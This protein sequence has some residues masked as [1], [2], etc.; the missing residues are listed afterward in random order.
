MSLEKMYNDAA[1]TSYVGTVRDRQ[2]STA[3]GAQLVNFLDGKAR[4]RT[5]QA[6]EFQTEFT[7]NE[8]GAYV[9]GGAQAPE[10]QPSNSSN[11]DA[12]PQTNTRWTNKAFKLAF[13]GQGPPQLNSGF[14]TNQFRPMFKGG[15]AHLYTPLAGK[16]FSDSNF[17]AKTRKDSSPSGAPIF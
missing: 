5:A 2:S 8:A 11:S 14:Y 13:D 16:S 15:Q 6:D 9:A 12:G 3:T 17:W 7:R 4:T 10:L 1:P